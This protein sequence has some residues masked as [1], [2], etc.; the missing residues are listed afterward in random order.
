M[1][2]KSRKICG[3]GIFSQILLLPFFAVSITFAPLSSAPAP[4]AVGLNPQNA[5]G[6]IHRN[7]GVSS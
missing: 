1:R 3:N 6:S 2:G 5:F 7:T 4:A